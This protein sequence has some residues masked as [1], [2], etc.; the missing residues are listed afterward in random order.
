M[1]NWK[2]KMIEYFAAGATDK[3]R[4]GVELEHFIVDKI[5]GKAIPYAGKNGIRSVLTKL[6]EQY[7][8]AVI[9]PEDDFLG[10]E[11][12]DFT[13]TLE[14]AAQ[15]EISIRPVTSVRAAEE[16][17]LDF[18]PRINPILSG[19]GYEM[20]TAGCQ[21]V[22]RMEEL[23][24][25]PKKRYAIM[26][27][28]FKSTGTGGIEMMRGTSSTQVSID[29]S[30]EEDF[31]RKIRAA[32]YYGPILKLLT[33]NSRSFQGRMLDMNLKRTDIWRRTDPVRCGILPG[34]FSDNYGFADYADFIGHVPP[35][36]L[37]HGTD[38]ELTGRSTV[39]EIFADR[40][41]DEE[42]LKHVLSMV[43]PDVRLKQYLEIRFADSVPLPFVNA[44]SA[45]I[46]GLF[47]SES[48]LEFA[49]EEIRRGRLKEE[50]I[51]IS[52]DDIMRRG[53]NAAVYNTGCTEQAKRVLET[54]CEGLD[55]EEKNYLDPFEDVIL[56][57]G[58]GNIP[59]NASC[60]FQKEN[61]A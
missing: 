41:M 61:I 56:H 19:M 35:V 18:L 54:A 39:E 57:G 7:P 44:Y 40:E 5:T 12:P 3:K 6:M 60:H 43:F 45:L 58:I 34:I 25:I 52:E 20:I 11:V 21:P 53:W 9:I 14:P 13:V 31:S 1:K 27:N 23:T 8:D 30:S 24:L 46:K 32:Y 59:V 36:F 15:F 38:L 4:L 55:S 26:N 29:Y 37:K 50:D 49:G 22:S 33:D 28:H 51:L 2:S 10:F 42:L 17:Y 48:G 47:Y 16:I